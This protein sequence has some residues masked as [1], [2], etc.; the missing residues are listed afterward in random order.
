MTGPMR[1]NPESENV[2]KVPEN[3]EQ[4]DYDQ[5]DSYRGTSGKGAA[6]SVEDCP[7]LF[8]NFQSLQRHCRQING[9]IRNCRHCQRI[10]M[11]CSGNVAVQQTVNGSLRAAAGTFQSG[12]HKEQAFGIQYSG[13]RV[14]DTV[15]KN[16]RCQ[17]YHS[18]NDCQNRNGPFPAFCKMPQCAQA[19]NCSPISHQAAQVTPAISRIMYRTHQ[20]QDITIPQTDQFLAFLENVRASS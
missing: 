11:H 2:G 8:R 14:V 16:S 18:G 15:K 7:S 4:D 3:P 6:D 19:K 13:P 12:K 10:I 20:K 17:Q 5:N 1:G 9:N